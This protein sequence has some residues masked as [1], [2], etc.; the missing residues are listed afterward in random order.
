[1]IQRI[2]TLYLALA[3]VIVTIPLVMGNL[4][5]ESTAQNWFPWIRLGLSVAAAVL[6]MVAVFGY[7]NRKRQSATAFYAQIAVLLLLLVV[8]ATTVLY[9]A[10]PG[11]ESWTRDVFHLSALGLPAVSY[12]LFGLARRAI[13]RDTD[14]VKSMD[15]LRP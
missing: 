1:M 8:A 9:G 14:L 3:S 7:R 6:G 11:V 4:N 13:R 12:V 15:R 5:I 2:Q 10:R